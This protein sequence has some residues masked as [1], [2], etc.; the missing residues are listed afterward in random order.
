MPKL[1]RTFWICLSLV[2]ITVALFWPLTTCQFVNFDDPDYVYQNPY[3]SPGLTLQNLS[4]ALRA[5]YASN[6]HPLTWVS[7]MI[8]CDMFGLEPAG[9]HLTNV[10]FHAANAALLFLLLR[11]MTGAT[12]RS[13]FV[14]ALFAWHPLH[15]ESVAWVSER[16]D[17]LSAFFFFLTIWAYVEYTKS[18]LLRQEHSGGQEVSGLKS[19]VEAQQ[20]DVQ[21]SSFKFQGRHR[22]VRTLCCSDSSF[23]WYFLALFLFA[24]GLMSKPMLVTT[25]FVL[26]LLDFWPLGRFQPATFNIQLS[27]VFRLFREKLPF[28][29]LAVLDCMMTVHAQRP[30]AMASLDALPVPSRI[31]NALVSY[32]LYLWKTVWPQNLAVLYPYSHEWTF[33]TAVGA[34]LLLLAISAAALWQ[35]RRRP[36]VTVGWFWFLGTLVPVIGLVQVGMHSMAD[37]YTY[38][39]LIGIFIMAVWGTMDS[40]LPAAKRG[41]GQ[42]EGSVISFWGLASAAVLVTLTICTHA[43][44]RYWHD[45]VTLWSRAIEVIPNNLRAEYNLGVAL[46]ERGDSQEAISHYL[47]A[48]QI[49]PDRVEARGGLPILA[50]QNLGV[51][52]AR[53][54]NWTEA[55]THFR[56]VLKE[57]PDDWEARGNLAGCLEVEGRFE[58]AIKEF[59]TALQG[60][61]DIPDMWRRFANTLLKTGRSTE[62][63][64]AY[65]Q[66]VKLNPS[67][68]LELNDLAWFLAT[69]PHPE[70]RNGAEAITLAQRA[71]ELTA[72]TQPRCL[73]T[74]DAAYAEAG[75]F[76]EAIDTAQQAQKLALEQGQNG[77]AALAAERLELYRAGKPYRQH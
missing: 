60:A 55:E 58:E 17:V 42:G 61:P 71:C 37:R 59:R 36:Y 49:R 22:G 20:P 62:A 1:G 51:L 46:R 15:V 39:P 66:A 65:R 47:K 68:V 54:A 73:G 52:L 26:L 53:Q 23:V 33:W 63:E 72:G 48:T 10:L 74:L 75:R 44:L 67:G 21:V 45:S 50:H 14:A 35:A 41:E 38:I 19:K 34:G 70:L 77:L 7:H 24:L 2:V 64:K 28:F 16:K 3:V 8:D 43:Q 5:S 69:D 56:A 12:W 40:P 6:W 31:A 27:T 4:W 18:N 76:S 9:H 57:K 30:D 32:V 29:A 25:P 13:A 11:K